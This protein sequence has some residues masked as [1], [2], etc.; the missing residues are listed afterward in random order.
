MLFQRRWLFRDRFFEALCELGATAEPSSIESAKGRSTDER[1]SPESAHSPRPART[2]R[3]CRLA[4]RHLL[5]ESLRRGSQYAVATISSRPLPRNVPQ[6]AAA[7]SVLAV[8][9]PSRISAASRQRAS[10]EA[11]LENGAEIGEWRRPGVAR[12][13][14]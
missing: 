12:L 7:P 14:E 4:R 13:A 1:H 5:Q 11:F 6:R 2:G 9:G 10:C 8:F 3:R